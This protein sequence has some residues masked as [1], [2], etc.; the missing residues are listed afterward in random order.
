[1]CVCVCVCVCVRA[2]ACVRGGMCMHLFI[3]TKMNRSLAKMALVLQGHLVVAMSQRVVQ[4]H[5][6]AAVQETEMLRNR[7]LIDGIQL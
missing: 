4:H 2:C 7:V 3:F 1:M 6:T 5:Y